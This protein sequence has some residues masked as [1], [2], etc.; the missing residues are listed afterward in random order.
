MLFC[1]IHRRGKGMM[2][3]QILRRL[4]RDMDMA[5]VDME[6]ILMIYSRCS[7]PKVVWEGEAE[8]MDMEDSSFH[9]RSSE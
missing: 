5:L 2:M 3:E 1:L 4:S 6:S 8:D 9:T 7:F